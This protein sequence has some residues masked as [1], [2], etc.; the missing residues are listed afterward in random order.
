MKIYIIQY[1]PFC[2]FTSWLRKRDPFVTEMNDIVMK[3]ALVQKVSHSFTE[4]NPTIWTILVQ[5]MVYLEFII[6]ECFTLQHPLDSFRTNFATFC[7]YGYLLHHIKYHLGSL[8]SQFFP[9]LGVEAF[10]F[11]WHQEVWN[12]W[13]KVFNFFLVIGRSGKHRGNWI[14]LLQKINLSILF[15]ARYE[16]FWKKRHTKV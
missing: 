8:L 15:F 1:Q 6:M 16:T 12:C 5:I 7:Y 14:L 13:T 2:P 9:L 11:S 10:L 3:W 4:L